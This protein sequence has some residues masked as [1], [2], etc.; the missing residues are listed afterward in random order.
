MSPR[1]LCRGDDEFLV[2]VLDFI[3][4]FCSDDISSWS[5]RRL[6]SDWLLQEFR[7]AL[8]LRCC[9]AGRCVQ[10]YQAGRSRSRPT[11]IGG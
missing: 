8:S 7:A 5:W 6:N 9:L 2:D 11:G 1:Q 4:M 3:F 10:S